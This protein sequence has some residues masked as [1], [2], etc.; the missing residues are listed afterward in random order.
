MKNNRYLMICLYIIGILILSVTELYVCNDYF[1]KKMESIKK[2]L[3]ESSVVKED[4]SLKQYSK[5]MIVAH[6]DDDTIFG[7]AHLKD[8]DFV[9]MCVTCGV[10]PTRLQEFKTA[11]N[12]TDDKYIYLKHT[13]LYKGL[14]S[15]WIAEES[16]IKDDLVQIINSRDW[17]LIVTHNPDGEYGHIHHKKISK[18]VTEETKDKT[19]LYYFGIFH[20]RNELKEEDKNN[21]IFNKKKNILDI[22]KSQRLND[23]SRYQY[24][25]SHE[26]WIKYEDWN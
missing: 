16:D 3:E 6:P 21:E 17:N 18:I 19:K 10:N 22:Y 1:E 13:D 4:S 23:K 15:R 14:I 25:F 12:Y 7:G 9:V 24:M 11:M 5:L 2:P 8:D 26:D 20:S